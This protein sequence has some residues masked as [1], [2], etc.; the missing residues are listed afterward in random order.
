MKALS[1][2]RLF[3][4]LM[5]LSVL[6]GRPA[7]AQSEID[8]DHFESPNLEPFGKANSNANS[9]A[10]KVRY[11]GKFSLPYEVH[12]NGRRLP[13]GR[14]SVSV[15]SDGEVGQATLNQKDKTIGI[16]GIVQKQTHKRG[17]EAL[18]V[19]LRGKVRRLSAIQ[20]AELD[21]VFNSELQIENSPNGN[22]RRIEKLRLTGAPKK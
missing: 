6:G 21:L 3:A 5:A 12:C 16:P 19:E 22:P 14:Y 17:S 7:R 9:E 4:G 11:E 20:V 10:M 13:P 1:M 15:R 18:I 8:P 2:I